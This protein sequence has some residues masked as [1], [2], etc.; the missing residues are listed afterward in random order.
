M[1]EITRNLIAVL[2]LGGAL[3][4]DIIVRAYLNRRR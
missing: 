3:A 2:I 4:A 1:H